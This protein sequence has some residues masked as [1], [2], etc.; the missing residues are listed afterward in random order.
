MK[1]G[2]ITLTEFTTSIDNFDLLSDVD[3]YIT[4]FETNVSRLDLIAGY[5]TEVIPD[6]TTI[7]RVKSNTPQCTNYVD[8]IFVSPTPTPTITPTPTPTPSETPPVTPSVTPSNTPPVTPSVTPSNTPPV[9]RLAFSSKESG[10]PTIFWTEALACAAT[11]DSTVYLESGFSIPTVGQKFYEAPTGSAG[12]VVVSSARWQL[13]SRLGV[14]YAVRVGI[15]GSAGIITDV[16]LCSSLPSPTPTSTPSVTPSTPSTQITVDNDGGGGLGSNYYI[17]DITVDGITLPS[18]TQVNVGQTKIF[19][20][21]QTGT[22]DVVVTLQGCLNGSE[23]VTLEKAAYVEC[24]DSGCPITFDDSGAGI[25]FNGTNIEI[26]Y[27]G[28]ACAP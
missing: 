18:F 28:D 14:K 4:P 27:N 25:L 20:T 24:Y 2:T 6:A 11:T 22:L 15:G 7:I 1:C 5:D 16:T 19:Y 3:G 13:V 17:N 10:T 23:Y 12:W 26:Y 21:T 8:V 9:A